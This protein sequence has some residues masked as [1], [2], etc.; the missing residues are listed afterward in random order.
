MYNKHKVVNNQGTIVRTGRL[1]TKAV[2]K[3]K[4]LFRAISKKPL[5]QR[6]LTDIKKSATLYHLIYY[7]IV[8]NF[9]K[10]YK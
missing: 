7:P 3:P 10:L 5:P 8:Y 4:F 1:F 2:P 9:F 6:V